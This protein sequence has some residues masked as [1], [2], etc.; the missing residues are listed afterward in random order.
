[1]FSYLHEHKKGNVDEE[2]VKKHMG[3]SVS[4]GN[5]SYAEMIHKFDKIFGVSGTLDHL[6]KYDE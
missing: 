2:F 5:F 3:I 6:S 1:M 4:C